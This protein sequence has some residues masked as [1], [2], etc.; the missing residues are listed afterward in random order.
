MH[1]DLFPSLFF[2]HSLYANVTNVERSLARNAIFSMKW[3]LF[4]TDRRVTLIEGKTFV[5]RKN[6]IVTLFQETYL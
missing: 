4:G 2:M 6:E 3:A 1:G 5:K